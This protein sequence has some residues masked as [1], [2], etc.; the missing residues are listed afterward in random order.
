MKI[1]NK[2]KKKSKQ[3]RN[4]IGLNSIVSDPIFLMKPSYGI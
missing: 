3:K 1:D 4:N 2:I